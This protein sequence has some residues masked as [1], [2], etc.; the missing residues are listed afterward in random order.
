MVLIVGLIPATWFLFVGR[1]GLAVIDALGF[2][3]AAVSARLEWRWRLRRRAELTAELHPYD[4]VCA[5]CLYA[6]AGEAAPTS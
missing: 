5:K 2:V 3:W 1:P 4:W 6:Q